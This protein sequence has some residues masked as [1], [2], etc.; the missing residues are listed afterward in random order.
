MATINQF[1]Y[2]SDESIGPSYVSDTP[3]GCYFL[4]YY[5]RNFRL[6]NNIFSSAIFEVDKW[7]DEDDFTYMKKHKSKKNIFY[8]RLINYWSYLPFWSTIGTSWNISIN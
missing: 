3:F 2:V 7:Y 6:E 1:F 4:S 5:F 8:K